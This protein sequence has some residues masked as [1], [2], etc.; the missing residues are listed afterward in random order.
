MNAA[1]PIF[2][3]ILRTISDD[4]QRAANDAAAV[5]RLVACRVKDDAADVHETFTGLYPNT[6]AATVAGIERA[7]ERACSVSVRALP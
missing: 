6:C 4:A 5:Q 2:D 7:G 1:H 3:G